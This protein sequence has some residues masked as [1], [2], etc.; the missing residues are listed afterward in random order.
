MSIKIICD[1][2]K[3]PVEDPGRLSGYA[4]ISIKRLDGWK[5]IIFGERNLDL[6]PNCLIDLLNIVIY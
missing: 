5:Y 3:A 2:C 4:H 6:C 1:K